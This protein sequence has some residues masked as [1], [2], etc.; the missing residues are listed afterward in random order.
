MWVGEI[1][2]DDDG[3]VVM[4]CTWMVICV[5]GCGGYCGMVVHAYGLVVMSDML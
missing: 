5:V 4:Y 3:I 2:M 1:R